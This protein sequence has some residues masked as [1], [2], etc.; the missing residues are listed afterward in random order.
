MRL[1][2][3]RTGNRHALLLSARER[4][5]QTIFQAIKVHAGKQ[6]PGSRPAPGARLRAKGLHHVL[7]G[8]EV[9]E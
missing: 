5:R 3:E 8:R 4:R 6:G 1:A 7:D 9:R 2:G